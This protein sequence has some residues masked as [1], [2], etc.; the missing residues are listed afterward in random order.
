MCF[1][2]PGIILL[3]LTWKRLI[4][5]KKIKGQTTD[6]RQSAKTSFSEKPQSETPASAA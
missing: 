1:G 6:R 4:L 3:N 2:L 5:P